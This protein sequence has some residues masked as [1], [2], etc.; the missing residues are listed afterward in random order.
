MK[1]G[2][3]RSEVTPSPTAP[4]R[5]SPAPQGAMSSIAWGLVG[6]F[7]A[8]WIVAGV[9]TGLASR[10][11]S[12]SPQAT[13]C[14][15]ETTQ[16]SNYVQPNAGG[17]ASDETNRGAPAGLD[18]KLPPEV[19]ALAK[20]LDAM[21][22]TEMVANLATQ[23]ELTKIAWLDGARTTGVGGFIVGVVVTLFLMGKRQSVS[24][25]PAA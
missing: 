14:F 16:P 13:F 12:V 4:L 6:V 19:L 2:P 24:E 23:L 22:T 21:L 8:L 20:K 3:H 1:A 10:V 9:R 25:S 7:V 17:S 18:V 11:Q 5:C 15:H